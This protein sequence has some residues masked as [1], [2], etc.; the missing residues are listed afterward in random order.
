L[1][2]LTDGSDGKK[3]FDGLIKYFRSPSFLEKKTGKQLVKSVTKDRVN[4][5]LNTV[6]TLGDQNAQDD[7]IRKS[8]L[9][10]L[11]KLY[12]DMKSRLFLKDNMA[13]LN[14]KFTKGVADKGLNQLNKIFDSGDGRTQSFNDIWKSGESEARQV[15]DVLIEMFIGKKEG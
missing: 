2:A 6:T 3:V 10:V 8:T 9:N 7:N 5:L 14:Q 4:E 15:F 13:S 12:R 1:G 11:Q